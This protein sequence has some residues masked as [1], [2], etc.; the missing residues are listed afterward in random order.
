M[1]I[2]YFRCQASTDHA[3]YQNKANLNKVKTSM[4]AIQT[5]YAWFKWEAI[6]YLLASPQYIEYMNN[7]EWPINTNDG[8]FFAK[9]E[10]LLLR[11]STR[12]RRAKLRIERL[13]D[14][15]NAHIRFW[16]FVMSLEKYTVI[17]KDHLGDW[18]PEKDCC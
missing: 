7:C 12:P 13:F 16:W 1:S 2:C 15:S 11:T 4:W 6:N 8:L 9:K 17:E 3:T 18:S 14:R 5:W 10:S